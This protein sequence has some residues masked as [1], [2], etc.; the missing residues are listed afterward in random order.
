[1]PATALPARPAGRLSLAM[2]A[3][4]LALASAGVA[5]ALPAVAQAQVTL[6]VDIAP[7]PLPYYEQPPIPG[8][9]QIWTPGYWAWDDWWGDYYW[10]PGTWVMAP[11]AGLLWTPGWWGWSRGRY[12]WH[13][14]YWGA[15][16]GWYGGVNYGYGYNGYGYYGGEWRG[17]RF[18]YNNA[19]T[20]VR[21]PAV[22]T[23]FSRPVAMPPRTI[24]NNTRISYSGGPGGAVGGP[25]AAQLAAMRGP[26][27]GPVDGQM[28]VMRGAQGNRGAFAS[29][30]MGRPATVAVARP[31][32][33][34]ISAGHPDGMARPGPGGG[35]PAPA[36]RAAMSRIHPGAPADLAPGGAGPTRRAEPMHPDMG[37]VRP[38]DGGADGQSSRQPV[39][40]APAMH[41]PRIDQPALRETAMP[42]QAMPEQRRREAMPAPEMR[43]QPQPGRPEPMPA[44]G[45][46]RPAAPNGGGEPHGGGD[47]HGG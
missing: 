40:R 8:P 47:H 20:N 13:G 34:P 5:I 15:R 6:I 7:P 35:H 36:L 14:G 33:V 4:L 45:M 10:V 18:F 3:P 39:P 42:R 28:A 25:M 2:V 43:M 30:N 46:G 16:V 1:M 19:V 44:P 37:G 22:D 11:R 29:V 27:V 31:G 23:V 12:A 41:A 32:A 17:Q 21:N 38:R 24:V 9:N 26:H